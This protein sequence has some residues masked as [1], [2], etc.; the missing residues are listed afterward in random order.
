MYIPFAE[1]LSE[2]TISGLSTETLTLLP[3]PDTDFTFP[4]YPTVILPLSFPAGA[5]TETLFTFSPVGLE[6]SYTFT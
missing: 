6:L 2:T 5:L 3:L 1:A 4:S